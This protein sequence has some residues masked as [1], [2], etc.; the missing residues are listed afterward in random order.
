MSDAVIY[1]Q[2]KRL[3]A[4][5]YESVPWK[6]FKW[7]I[8]HAQLNIFCQTFLLQKWRYCWESIKAFHGVPH[9]CSIAVL[10]LGSL[11]PTPKRYRAYQAKQAAKAPKDDVTT[12]SGRT[13][14]VG[15]LPEGE[16]RK[17]R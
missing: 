14:S 4:A 15:M 2:E 10:V 8:S 11:L 13:N 12:Q 6:C 16:D 17:G 1:K 3:P 5:V 9:I 7:F